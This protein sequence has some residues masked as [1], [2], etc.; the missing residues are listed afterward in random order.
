MKIRDTIEV[1]DI[2]KFNGFIPDYAD[3]YDIIQINKLKIGNLYEIKNIIYFQ[4][5][6]W[7]NIKDDIYDYILVPKESF[8]IISIKERYDLK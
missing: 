2:V 6:S 8:D 1:G 3:G 4:S 5:Y 7:Y